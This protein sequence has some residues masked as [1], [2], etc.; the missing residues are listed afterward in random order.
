[1]GL[2]LGR[3]SQGAQANEWR[4]AAGFIHRVANLPLFWAL[5]VCALGVNQAVSVPAVVVGGFLGSGF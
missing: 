4:K 2:G 3:A 5:R 1:M